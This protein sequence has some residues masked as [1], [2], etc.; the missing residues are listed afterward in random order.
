VVGKPHKKKKKG[1]GEMR[2]VGIGAARTLLR[3][4]AA[5]GIEAPKKKKP[6]QGLMKLTPKRAG[7]IAPFAIKL[8]E[9]W[10]GRMDFD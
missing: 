6:F 4:G 10:L 5:G 9:A 8:N 2:V 7:N 3:N 1:G